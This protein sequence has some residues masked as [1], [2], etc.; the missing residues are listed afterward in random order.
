MASC[1]SVADDKDYL[2][3]NDNSIDAK[4][5]RLVSS[6]TG[7]FDEITES[8]FDYQRSRIAAADCKLH[9]CF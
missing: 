2:C 9:F 4:K 6:P 8:S 1:E 3:F 5:C 7:Q